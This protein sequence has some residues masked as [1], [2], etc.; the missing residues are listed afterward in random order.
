MQILKILGEEFCSKVLNLELLIKM[1][2]EIWIL[3]LQHLKI[4]LVVPKNEAKTKDSSKM[5]T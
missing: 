1:E 3:N 4:Y 5:V 2:K